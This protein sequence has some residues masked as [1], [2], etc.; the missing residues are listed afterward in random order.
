MDQITSNKRTKRDPD[1]ESS[2]SEM[3]KLNAGSTP[4]PSTQDGPDLDDEIDL[5]ELFSTDELD[6]LFDNSAE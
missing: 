2:Y 1:A 3:C 5:S 6:T 4:G